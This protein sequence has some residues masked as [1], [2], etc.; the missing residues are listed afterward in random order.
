VY[1]SGAEALTIAATK[2][3]TRIKRRE[4]GILSR[5]MKDFA[6]IKAA[7]L[8][9]LSVETGMINLLLVTTPLF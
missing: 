1:H 8:R 2:H 6:A 9:I 4:F 3:L 7:V 5:I